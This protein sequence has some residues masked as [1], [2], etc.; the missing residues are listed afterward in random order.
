MEFLSS[1]T[2]EFFCFEV[3]LFSIFGDV[4]FPVYPAIEV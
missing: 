4:F 1:Q 3:D 2:V